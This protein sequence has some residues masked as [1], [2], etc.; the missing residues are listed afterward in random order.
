VEPI[1]Y[2]SNGRQ[3]GN[4]AAA[5]AI[6]DIEW[7]TYQW[8]VRTGRPSSNPAPAHVK[9]D[10]KTGQRM[11]DLKQVRAWHASRKGRGNWNGIGA[12]AR[13]PKDEAVTVETVDPAAANPAGE[14]ADA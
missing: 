2:K 7:E 3:Y 8:Y 12:R 10:D 1:S 5:A 11:Y 13:K 6:C 14:P 9:V 4:A